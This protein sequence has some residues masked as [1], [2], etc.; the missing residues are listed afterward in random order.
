MTSLYK[1][2]KKARYFGGYGSSYKSQT[3]NPKPPTNPIAQT[4]WAGLPRPGIRLG[5]AGVVSF[6]GMGVLLEFL[7]LRGAVEGLRAS[8]PLC[9]RYSQTK[10]YI[11]TSRQWNHP[12][13]TALDKASTPTT[14][15][16][17]EFSLS[18]PKL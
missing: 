3:L 15:I 9:N 10:K 7:G 5:G 11:G 16:S 12:R 17:P 18:Q 13:F 6:F 4:V 14:A 8:C 1:P 2:I